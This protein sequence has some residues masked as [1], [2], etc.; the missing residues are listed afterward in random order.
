MIPAFLLFFN[1]YV[2]GYFVQ[3]WAVGDNTKAPKPARN[4]SFAAGAAWRN[5]LRLWTGVWQMMTVTVM[6][7]SLNI[8][9]PVGEWEAELY[10]IYSASYRGSPFFGAAHVAGTWASMGLIVAWFQAYANREINPTFYKHATSSVIVVYIFHWDIIAPFVWWVCR[11]G[12]MMLGGWKLVDPLLTLFVGV[13]GSLGIYALLL[14][15]PPAGR[16][17]GL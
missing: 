13:V 7:L 8:G 15:Y 17:F 14:R 2:H 5:K 9:S 6:I 16:L 1:F 11:D 10:P 12:G 4:N 3:R